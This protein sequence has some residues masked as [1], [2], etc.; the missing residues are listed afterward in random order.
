MKRIVVVAAVIRRGNQVLV[1]DRPPDKPPMGWE[2]PGGKVEPGESIAEALRRELREELNVEAVVLDQLWVLSHRTGDREIVLHFLRCAID[3]D[4]E[5]REG[6]NWR[7]IDVS[8]LGAVD[9]LPPD[10]PVADF[11]AASKK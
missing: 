8:E 9:L 1:T 3:R 2:F 10:K 6:Q 5:P 7:Y 11:L 4:P